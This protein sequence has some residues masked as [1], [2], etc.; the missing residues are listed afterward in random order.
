MINARSALRGFADTSH[1]R[2]DV[3]LPRDRASGTR[4]IFAFLGFFTT[5]RS[6][7]Q[8]YQLLPVR[9]ASRLSPRITTVRIDCSLRGGGLKSGALCCCSVRVVL[10][11]ML[12]HLFVL[13]F[14]SKKGKNHSAEAGCDSCVQVFGS[15]L[16][17]CTSRQRT[18]SSR[19]RPA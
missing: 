4:F 17:S 2:V 9:G 10:S 1:K 5:S 15:I 6:H 11:C 7:G 16:F 12:F 3:T 8:A 18:S 14:P 19:F 13:R